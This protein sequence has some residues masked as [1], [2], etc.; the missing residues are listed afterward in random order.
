MH[1]SI[2]EGRLV[3]KMSR[4]LFILVGKFTICSRTMWLKV[5]IYD[6]STLII[7][8]NSTG[9]SSGV[10]C[11]VTCKKRS[12]QYVGQTEQK[13]SMRMNKLTFDIKHFP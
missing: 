6:F 9:I 3:Q 7:R 4:M 13:C 2:R 8:E 10:I 5:S 1:L 11:L 12:I